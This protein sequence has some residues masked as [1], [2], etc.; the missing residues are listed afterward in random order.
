[1][2]ARIGASYVTASQPD[3]RKLAEEF[4]GVTAPVPGRHG[5]RKR[6]GA[7]NRP[8][9][10]DAS[11]MGKQLALQVVGRA[12]RGM[13]L[14]YPRLLPQGATFVAPPRAYTVRSQSGRKQRA[15]RLVVSTGHIGEY[16][17]FQGL[18]W[19]RAP[20]LRSPSS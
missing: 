1:F 16:L 14:Y 18:T 7:R 6:G 2:T 5:G 4:L 20:I 8:S 9:V 17:G 11:A 13:R 15:Y 12:T 10:V 19:K 3:V